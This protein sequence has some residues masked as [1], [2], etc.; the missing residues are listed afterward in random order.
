MGQQKFM[1]TILAMIIQFTAP[2][3]F[4]LIAFWQIRGSFVMLMLQWLLL[5]LCW[6]NMN[7]FEA[8]KTSG[9]IVF[10][11]S[12]IGLYFVT[13]FWNTFLISN[14]NKSH[15]AICRFK[16][17]MD[18]SKDAICIVN[19]TKLHYVN[20]K[21]ISLFQKTITDFNYESGSHTNQN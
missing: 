12:G 20:D 16:K 11:F 4:N 10:I 6:Q 21:F 9:Y 7:K 13:Y 17:V 18:C 5:A 3:F 8:Y 1:N 14:L 2:M 19:R 15:E